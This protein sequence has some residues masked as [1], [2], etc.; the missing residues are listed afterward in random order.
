M[1]PARPSLG[2]LAGWVAPIG[3]DRAVAGRGRRAGSG[4]AIPG[5]VHLVGPQPARAAV[6]AA[7]V[8]VMAGPIAAILF[9]RTGR[10]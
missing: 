4:V 10:A 1:R 9:L 7:Y 8:L 5:L 3:S 2:R 6:L